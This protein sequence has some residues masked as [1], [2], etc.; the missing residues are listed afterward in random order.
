[1]EKNIPQDIQDKAKSYSEVC[2]NAHHKNMVVGAFVSG[3]TTERESMFE[4][5]EWINRNGY[6]KVGQIYDTTSLAKGNDFKQFTIQ[7][8]HELWK[9]TK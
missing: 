1:M 5:M 6:R 2:I 3:A 9:R 8:L 4:F 7:Q